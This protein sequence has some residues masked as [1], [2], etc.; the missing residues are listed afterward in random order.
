M[1][2]EGSGIIER[3]TDEEHGQPPSNGSEHALAA[4]LIGVLLAEHSEHSGVGQRQTGTAEELSDDNE[5]EEE[6]E[7]FAD[8]VAVEDGVGEGW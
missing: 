4:V 7:D 5:Q 1:V 6:E 8:V 2:A 3:Q